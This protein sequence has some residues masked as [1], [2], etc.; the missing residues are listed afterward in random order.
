MIIIEI[1]RRQFVKIVKNL[2]KVEVI[3][4]ENNE[5]IME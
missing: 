1:Y 4:V 2:V 5:I 3:I